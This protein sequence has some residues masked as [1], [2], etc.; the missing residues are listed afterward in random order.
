MERREAHPRPA[1][2]CP[3][4]RTNGSRTF[5]CGGGASIRS[6]FMR[7]SLMLVVVGLLLG[8]DKPKDETKDLDGTWVMVSGE[9]EGKKLSDE[10]GK[11]ARLVIKGN[12]H[13]VRVGSDI[14]KGTHKVDP[15]KKPKTIDA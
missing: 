8:A 2:N 1:Y 11:K 3:I 10:T 6:K 9:E 7:R 14:L 13:T 15:G 12:E 5:S 4:G